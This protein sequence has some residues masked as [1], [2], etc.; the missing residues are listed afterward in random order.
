MIQGDSNTSFYHISTLVKRKRNKTMAIRD[1]CGEWIFEES[2]VKEYIRS[3]FTGIYSTSLVSA[4][5]TYNLN[6]Q[7]QPRLSKEE[8]QSISGGGVTDEEIK[9]ALWS[10]KPFKAPGPNGLHAGFFQRFWLVV[11]SSV[12]EEIKLIFAEKRIANYINTTHIA[13]IPKI[14]GPVMLGNYKPISLCNT[15]YKVLTKIVVAKLRP[16]LGKL[17][18]PLQTA[19][20]PGRKGMDNVIIAQELIHSLSRKKGNTGYMAIKIDLE[21]AY[22]KI[23]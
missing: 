2:A 21:K 14:Q 9:A 13:L 4:P 10:L 5:I 12:I 18:S 16:Y 20:V 17:I 8:K 11:G 3:G 7:W 6:Y 15:V 19:F 1:T 22:D 23:E